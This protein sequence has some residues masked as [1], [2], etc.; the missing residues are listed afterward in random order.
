MRIL[1][2]GRGVIARKEEFGLDPK[3]LISSD[4]KILNFKTEL[5][6]LADTLAD[7]VA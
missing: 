6:L 1:T 3:S 4:V 5:I 7:N 2:F